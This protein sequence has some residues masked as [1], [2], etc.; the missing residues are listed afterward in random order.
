ML[1]RDQKVCVY[2]ISERLARFS[3]ASR[4]VLTV[5]IPIP[6]NEYSDV[7]EYVALFGERGILDVV[8]QKELRSELVDFIREE[9]R[10]I[11]EERDDAI[12][13]KALE[14]GF[15]TPETEKTSNL[16]MDR[17]ENF[18]NKFSFVMRN[19]SRFQ[20]AELMRRQ[21]LM[22][23]EMNQ[24][25][26]V[27]DW[28]MADIMNKCES[29]VND[30]IDN[31]DVHPHELSKLNEKLRVCLLFYL[32][33]FETVVYSV[34]TAQN[35]HASYACQIELLVERQ[36]RDFR[37]TLSTGD[38]EDSKGGLRCE[39]IYEIEKS[40]TGQAQIFDN[41]L[42]KGVDVGSLLKLSISL[43]GRQ[44]SGLVLLVPRDPLWHTTNGSGIGFF[45]HKSLFEFFCLHV[46]ITGKI[47]LIEK[48]LEKRIAV[49]GTFNTAVIKRKLGSLIE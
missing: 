28:E 38:D 20:L 15:E 29:A 47:S 31:V 46:D 27:R 12:I 17:H 32:G 25:I 24:I 4:D 43:Y 21:I 26:R 30:V 33:C 7:D 48:F 18:A 34:Y 11:Q 23:N 10:K 36:K 45:F 44:L 40:E 42:L 49:K 2:T 13:K 39:E 16:V 5:E 22:M 37:S 14:V 35:L 3:T 6:L 1:D 9:T 41:V 8:D 19:S